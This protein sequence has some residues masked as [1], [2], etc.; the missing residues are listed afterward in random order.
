MRYEESQGT[1]PVSEMPIYSQSSGLHF[2]LNFTVALA[3]LIGV[4]LLW[5][6]RHGRVIWLQVWSAGLIVFSAGYL[7]AAVFDRV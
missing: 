7:V 2:M 3:L 6:G 5:L 1:P 4:A